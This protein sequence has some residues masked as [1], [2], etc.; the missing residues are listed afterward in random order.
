MGA[1]GTEGACIEWVLSARTSEG[2]EVSTFGPPV[3]DEDEWAIT[4]AEVDA[5]VGVE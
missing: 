1:A 2:V 4:Q 5:V 3:C